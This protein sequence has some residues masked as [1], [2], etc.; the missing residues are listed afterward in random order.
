MAE[1]FQYT[2]EN[3]EWFES[4]VKSDEFSKVLGIVWKYGS[5]KRDGFLIR[6]K[7]REIIDNFSSL[8][9]GVT[10]V[11]SLFRKDKDFVEWYCNISLNH[12]FLLKIKQ[13]GW[14][15][16]IEEERTYP[17]GEF[18]HEIFIKTYILM[19]HDVGTIR[20]KNKKGAVAICARL[21]IHGS[22]DMLQHINQ[23]LH[24]KLGVSFKKLQTDEKVERA[25]IL[26]YQSKKE[27]PVILKYIDAKESLE[28]FN[29]F[30][31]GYVEN[32]GKI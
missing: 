4:F 1:R 25:K 11:K 15:P 31:L 8:I 22:T 30:K 23:H 32:T 5:E 16:R 18:N 10:P 24:N 14:K 7:N 19:R 3:Q 28:K 21:R 6:H 12:P 26:C 2:L 20:K 13:M 29:S 9:R 17:K 27:I